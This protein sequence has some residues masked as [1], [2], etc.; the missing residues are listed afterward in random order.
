MQVV[1]RVSCSFTACACHDHTS[2]NARNRGRGGERARW[3]RRGNVRSKNWSLPQLGSDGYHAHTARAEPNCESRQVFRT[4]VGLATSAI[5][6]AHEGA[7]LWWLEL[8]RH[9]S[10]HCSSCLAGVVDFRSIR[11]CRS[12]LRTAPRSTWTGHLLLDAMATSFVQMRRASRAVPTE[13]GAKIVHC[14]L[15]FRI[16]GSP[17]FSHIIFCLRE[18]LYVLCVRARYCP[19]YT[20]SSGVLEFRQHWLLQATIDSRSRHLPVPV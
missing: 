11:A 15:F 8:R 4:V 17:P 7:S 2:R 20:G 6:R 10:A 13:R 14:Y 1:A 19:G 9:A 16:H 12:A 3:A 18:A 5:K